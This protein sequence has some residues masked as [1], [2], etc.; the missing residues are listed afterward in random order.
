LGRFTVREDAD[1]ALPLQERTRLRSGWV[2]H[3]KSNVM[4]ASSPRQAEGSP[5]IPRTNN[6]NMH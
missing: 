5:H 3:A 2:T 6:S 1:M 4:T